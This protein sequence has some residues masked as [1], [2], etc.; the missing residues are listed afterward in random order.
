[1]SVK[2]V[3][4]FIH[5][6]DEQ[7]VGGKYSV[8]NINLSPRKTFDL[9]LQVWVHKFDNIIM[10]MSLFASEVFFFNNNEAGTQTIF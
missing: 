10:T 1:M 7:D 5:R 2:V 4:L 9:G 6:D 8:L 3:L